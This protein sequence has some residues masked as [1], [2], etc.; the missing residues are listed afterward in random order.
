MEGEPIFSFLP[1]REKD[2]TISTQFF[3]L[4]LD[5]RL[6]QL[7]RKQSSEGSKGLKGQRVSVSTRKPSKASCLR[8]FKFILNGADWKLT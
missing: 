8:T 3:S 7:N 6:Q 5:R 1:K 4:F 2:K